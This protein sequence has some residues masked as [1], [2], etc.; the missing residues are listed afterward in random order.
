MMSKLLCNPIFCNCLILLSFAMSFS[1]LLI[2]LSFAREVTQLQHKIC[3]DNVAFVSSDTHINDLEMPTE[4]KPQIKEQDHLYEPFLSTPVFNYSTEI[5]SDCC[6]IAPVTLK[7]SEKLKY[8]ETWKSTPF[9]TFEGGYL[10]YVSVNTTD[11]YNDN[12]SHLPLHV[13]LLKG[14]YDD[15][16]QQSGYWPM[17]G[18]FIIDLFNQSHL[19]TCTQCSDRVVDDVEIHLG[20]LSFIPYDIR[21]NQVGSDYFLN[22]ALDFKFSFLTTNIYHLNYTEDVLWFKYLI[23]HKLEAAINAHGM[24]VLSISILRLTLIFYEM[25]AIMLVTFRYNFNHLIYVTR[26]REAIMPSNLKLPI[27]ILYLVWAAD[28]IV[29]CTSYFMKVDDEDIHIP[30]LLHRLL[31]RLFVVSEFNLV[32]YCLSCCV[33]LFQSFTFSC[34]HDGLSRF[35]CY[36][37]SNISA[38]QSIGGFDLLLCLLV[39]YVY[40][41]YW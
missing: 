32:G 19:Y 37:S 28:A 30:M 15:N 23:Y 1:S 3:H 29:L 4:Y 33:L 35:I 2:C 24:M 41:N 9:F 21:F 26:F 20:L 40:S 7:T 10:I 16:L 31:K 25:C 6:Q 12:R 18:M 14:L 38:A 39:G 34:A 22:E 27:L 13:H 5:P 11:F 17:R 8:N 36:D